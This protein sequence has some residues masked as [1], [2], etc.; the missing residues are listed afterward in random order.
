VGATCLFSLLHFLANEGTNW[1]RAIN[2]DLL[3]S[4]I[5]LVLPRQ[6]N[7]AGQGL[8]RERLLGVWGRNKGLFILKQPFLVLE[9]L[10]GLVKRGL[11]ITAFSFLVK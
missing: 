1:F 3:G 9:V 5:V 10:K 11:I 4:D 7:S 2:A 6:L 8:V